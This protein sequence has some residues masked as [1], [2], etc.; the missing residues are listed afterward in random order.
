MTNSSI[1][2]S[3]TRP[4]KLCS[5]RAFYFTETHNR[6]YYKCAS[7]TLIFLDPNHYVSPKKE[8]TRYET[9]NNDVTDI[10]YQK[11]V[12][13]IT[14]AVESRFASTSIGLDY[15]CGTGPV[16]TYVLQ[17]KGFK[18]I[19]L[20]DPYFEPHEEYLTS[21]TYDFIIC[22]E[23]MEHFYEPFKEFKRLSRLLT[24][25]GVLYCKTKLFSDKQNAKDFEKWHYKNDET[26]VCFY[27]EKNLAFIAQ[28]FGLKLDKKDNQLISF[29]A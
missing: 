10:R 24:S 11:F 21:N 28:E 19:K 17:N 6:L 4:C 7:C 25:G 3:F 29:I 2:K 15:G 1:K 9:H 26:H 22:C 18:N 12:L 8:Q 20:Y 14:A 27:N 23:V 5:G 13:P 16:A